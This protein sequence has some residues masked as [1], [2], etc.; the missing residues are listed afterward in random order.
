MAYNDGTPSADAIQAIVNLARSNQTQ[1]INDETYTTGNFHKIQPEGPPLPDEVKVTTLSGLVE[2]VTAK[3][4]DV[5][6]G[7]WLVHVVDH[8]EVNLIK[9]V[10]DKFGRRHVMAKAELPDYQG[11]KFGS[12][13]E[14]DSFI[15]SL[16]ANFSPTQG[17]DLDYLLRIAS[18][19][20]S[21]QVV[22]SETDQV[23]QKVGMRA[24]VHMQAR[25]GETLKHRVR[26]APFRTFGEVEQPVSE[27]VFRVQPQK[28]GETTPKV[29]CMTLFEADGGRW[30]KDAMDKIA[31]YM[32]RN[33]S[34]ITVVC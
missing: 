1:T 18:N 22:T 26:L 24:G 7:D 3:V 34:K 8:E 9:R 28:Q 17:D 6:E 4:D 23:S 27:F 13:Y 30:K 11:F 33:S 10:A 32:A 14:H 5:S 19:V 29:P 2:L 31:A 12:W 25:E 16:L 20:T 15:I 21:E